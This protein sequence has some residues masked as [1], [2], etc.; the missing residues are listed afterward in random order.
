MWWFELYFQ[1]GYIKQLNLHTFWGDI[2]SNII[3]FLLLTSG[4]QS[5]NFVIACDCKSPSCTWRVSCTI[6]IPSINSGGCSNFQSYNRFLPYYSLIRG[7]TM[8]ALPSHSAKNFRSRSHPQAKDNVR[9]KLCTA[10]WRGT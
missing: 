6:R 3:I 2:Y 1:C 4:H 7:P 10:Y 5:E 8:T 9:S